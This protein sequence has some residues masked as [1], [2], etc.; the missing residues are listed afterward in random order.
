MTFAGSNTA[1]AVRSWKVENSSPRGH[2]VAEV[3]KVKLLHVTHRLN[4]R[5]DSVH[6]P[7]CPRARRNSLTKSFAHI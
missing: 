4:H 2:Q 3:R 1:G 7:S 6:V 5:P